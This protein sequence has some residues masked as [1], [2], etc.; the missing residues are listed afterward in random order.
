MKVIF[1]D[2]AV[3]I[4]EIKLGKIFMCEGRFYIKVHDEYELN[5]FDLEYE[6]LVTVYNDRK[7]QPKS[8]F[9]T[10]ED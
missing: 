7:V 9:L 2:K 1:K 8:G 6:R 5:A 4:K 10:I 3:S